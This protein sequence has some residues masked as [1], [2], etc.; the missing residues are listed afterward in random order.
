MLKRIRKN[1]RGEKTEGEAPEQLARVTDATQ[2]PAWSRAA[3]ARGGDTAGSELTIAA[4]DGAHEQEADRAA[5]QAGTG[6]AGEPLSRARVPGNASAPAADQAQTPVPSVVHQT[7][8]A[9]GQPL[10]EGT[11]ADLKARFDHDF[12]DVRVHADAQAAES[13][14]AVGAKAYTV[15]SH[16]VFGPGRYQ[17]ET[18]PGRQ[19]I[20]HEAAHVVQ[21]SRSR[22]PMV[23]RD[24][25]VVQMPEETITSTLR[26]ASE[27]VSG[28]ES[29][30]G[31]GVTP[32]D[33]SV[34]Y[35][36]ETVRRNAPDATAVLPFRAGG[37]DGDAIM[38]R[39]GQ[40]DTVPGTDSD[41]LRCVQAVALVSRIIHGPQAVV[42]FLRASI[43]DGMLSR[44]MGARQRT[45]IDVL[46]H[47][48]A[49]IEMRHAT[50][51]DLLFAQEALHD[52][53]Y[54]DVTGT[55]GDEMAARIAP[56]LDLS[57]RLEPMNVWC[58]TPAEVIAQA[59]QL[60][61]GE[62]LLVNTWQVIFNTAFD[63]LSE[64]GIEV[65]EGDSIQ[66]QINGQ[67]RRIRRIPTATRPAHSIIDPNR[68]RQLGHQLLVFRDPAT[69]ALR[70]YEPEVTTSGQHLEGLAQDG[71]N[72]A[73]YFQD[74]A[75]LGIYNYIQVLGKLTPSSWLE[76]G[77]GTP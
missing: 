52:L 77:A 19:L 49:R 61:P 36:E 27:A 39:L 67:L 2:V 16:V 69:Q 45:A 14:R 22:T 50:F 72:F 26:P 66:V 18:A 62:Q 35:D 4:A 76:T 71:S 10:D 51:G 25:D 53:F 12:G 63:E 47:V 8:R 13:A 59:N 9:P 37:W 1:R 70:L 65:Q 5:Q 24:V 6:P 20:A 60:Q 58:N 23:Q 34:A 15:G 73:R 64:Q 57:T 30:R 32:G 38:T 40:Y 3:P 41:A 48:I 46:E 7:L 21:Q 29:L 17:P 55:P 31:E 33:V 68:D 28:L 42:S 74:H 43:L 44:P 54:N 56:A 75:D 11:R